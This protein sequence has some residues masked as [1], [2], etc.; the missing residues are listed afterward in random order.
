VLCC[1]ELKENCNAGS[2]RLMVV[3]DGVNSLFAE[4][5]MINREKTKYENGPYKP[6]GD[7]LKNV[8]E[9]GHGDFI[10]NSSSQVVFLPG[11]I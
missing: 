10:R 7:F 5:T 1:R 6:W 4:K 3:C 8:A 11:V 9:V 2:C